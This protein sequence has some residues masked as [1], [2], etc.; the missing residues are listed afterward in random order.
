[1]GSDSWV[2]HRG[3]LLDPFP[4][5]RSSSEKDGGGG[6]GGGG[7]R[8]GGG[9]GGGVPSDRTDGD[10][11]RGGSERKLGGESIPPRS[12]VGKDTVSQ[13]SGGGG[14]AESSGRSEME[15]VWTLA[16]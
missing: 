1:M 5:P 11:G 7:G 16:A 6:G 10:A 3:G 12:M 2:G 15:S 14:G 8:G 9:G 13:A 4:S